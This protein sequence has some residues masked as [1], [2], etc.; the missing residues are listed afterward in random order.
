[1]KEFVIGGLDTPKKKREAEAILKRLGYV[2]RVE[3][4]SL[5]REDEEFTFINAYKMPSGY[6]YSYY[7]HKCF[8]T[9]ITLKELKAIANKE[10]QK[11]KLDEAIKEKT[12][13]FINL[14]QKQIGGEID[15][16]NDNSG[17]WLEIKRGDKILTFSFDAEGEEVS[18]VKVYKEI[19][20]EVDHEL[21]F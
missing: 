20:K 3:W 14:L 16:L 4:N 7:N 21:I 10:G 6:R 1:M 2:D 18:S 8:Q 13:K 19:T 5:W 11:K 9:P 12:P 17:M 15:Q